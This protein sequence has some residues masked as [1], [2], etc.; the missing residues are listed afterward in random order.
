MDVSV[1]GVR[2]KSNGKESEINK[3]SKV[4]KI[5][6]CF[7]VLENKVA[8]KGTKDVYVRV[9]SPDGSVLTTSQETFMYNNQAQLYT[10][11]DSFDYNN[12]K[13][14]ICIYYDKGSA[15]SKGKYSIELYCGGN[16]IG[17]ASFVL[18]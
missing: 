5:K 3:A 2:Y 1:I 8:D 11:K 9:L 15:Y 16:Q 12:E 18:K 6:T 4:Q 14:N 10:V 7:T 13:A 17:S